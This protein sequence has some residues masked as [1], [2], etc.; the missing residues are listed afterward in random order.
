MILA[1]EL[2]R[3]F[4][5]VY[6]TI[7]QKADIHVAENLIGDILDRDRD[8]EKMLWLIVTLLIVM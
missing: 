7:K 4:C 5:R 1:C 6:V 2:V 3:D 8:N